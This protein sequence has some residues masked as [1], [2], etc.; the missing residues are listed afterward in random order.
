MHI[1]LMR[2][3]G[4]KTYKDSTEIQ[5]KQHYNCIVGLNGSGKSNILTGIA[6]VLADLCPLG[7]TDK[8]QFL[9]EGASKAVKH[10]SVE[11]VFDNSDRSF[12]LYKQ[13]EVSVKRVVTNTG[14]DEF[15]IDNRKILKK[16]FLEALESLGFSKG[17]PYYIVRQGKVSE[18]SQISD[19]KRLD[20]FSDVSGVRGYEERRSTSMRLLLEKDEEL[21]AADDSLQIIGQKMEQLH[22]Q[23]EE[24]REYQKLCREKRC[25]EYFITYASWRDAAMAEKEALK[26]RQVCEIAFHRTHCEVSKLR[27]QKEQAEFSQS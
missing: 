7:V 1:K 21:Q 25:L 12:G 9:H 10:A 26:R 13:E 6:F 27:D 23:T 16:D 3:V 11:L 8:S 19:K 22:E 24:L 15:F 4:F 14:R 20:L 18:L 17:N 5:F 2:M